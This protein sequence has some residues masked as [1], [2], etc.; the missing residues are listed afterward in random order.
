MV[1]CTQKLG[2]SRINIKAAITEI[3]GAP[4]ASLG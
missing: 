3:V 4:N 1:H 2:L